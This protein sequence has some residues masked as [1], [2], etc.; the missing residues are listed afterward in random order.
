MSINTAPIVNL[1][2][3]LTSDQAHDEHVSNAMRAYN[4]NDYPR[5]V[6]ELIL[7]LDIDADADDYAAGEIRAALAS[8]SAEEIAAIFNNDGQEFHVGETYMGSLVKLVGSRVYSHGT[9]SIYALPGGG[10][11]ALTDDAWDLVEF[12]E[13]GTPDD[14]SF[15][16][17]PGGWRSVEIGGGWNRNGWFFHDAV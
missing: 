13:D 11:V 3:S 6:R 2:N 15:D 9:D 8:A 10:H 1:I 5:T 12:D 17:E 16:G 4:D 14:P 7:G